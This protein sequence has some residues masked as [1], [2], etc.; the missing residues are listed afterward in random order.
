[1]IFKKSKPAHRLPGWPT[2]RGYDL[3]V[4]PKPSGD[5]LIVIHGFTHDGRVMKSLTSPNGESFHPASLDSLAAKEGVLVCYPNGTPLTVMPGRCWNG[6]G[7]RNGFCAVAKK[8]VDKNVD[9]VRYLEK[10]IEH[11]SSTHRV[12]RVFLAGI[13]N[14]AA[15]AHRFATERPSQLIGLA[16][17]A[18][19]NQHA[20]SEKLIPSQPI[21]ILHIHGTADPIWPYDGGKIP[22]QGRLDSVV[23][24]LRIW[25]EANRANLCEEREL[26]EHRHEGLRVTLCRYEGEQ[27]IELYRVEGGGHTWPGGRQYLPRKVVGPVHP[28]FSASTTILDF[29]KRC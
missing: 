29:L 23:S 4:P 11:L 13:S 27:P 25:A 19:C 22:T 9:D 16:V 28:T 5:L 26:P 14:G 2:G 21:P 12:D 6:G 20:A 3:A 24:S 15:L 1:M 10:L 7:G 8:A 18:G 17:V